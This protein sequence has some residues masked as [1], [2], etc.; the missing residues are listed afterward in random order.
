MQ[1]LDRIANLI[2]ED[3]LITATRIAHRLGYAEEKTVYYWLRK[4]HYAG[5]NAF[6]KAVLR[7]QFTPQSDRAEETPGLY[8]RLPVT[9]AWTVEGQPIFQ[10]DSITISSGQP[11]ELVWR[12]PGPPLQSILP[13][14]LLVLKS[15]DPRIDTPWVVAHTV[16][17]MALR[18][19]VN[20][21]SHHVFIHPVTMERDTKCR[22]MYQILQLVRHF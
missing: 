16:E 15:L 10:G 18:V 5:L 8:G 7:G 9:D 11:A 21:G 12:Y 20:Y 19:Q 2:L 6:K 4:S 13:Q 3:P 14:D 17:G 22:P 1:V